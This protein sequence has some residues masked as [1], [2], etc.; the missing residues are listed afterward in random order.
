MKRS[1]TRTP[2]RQQQVADLAF[3]LSRPMAERIA[4]VEAL[5]EQAAPQQPASDAEQR[6]QRICRIVKRAR[7]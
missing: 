1:V 4:A 5:R 2:K 7:R 3:W 6:F